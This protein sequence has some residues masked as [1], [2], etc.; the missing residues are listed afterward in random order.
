MCLTAACSEQLDAHLRT[1]NENPAHR[2]RAASS[3]SI[4]GGAPPPCGS[5]PEPCFHASPPLR[6]RAASGSAPEPLNFSSSCGSERASAVESALEPSSSAASSC[7]HGGGRA[8]RASHD[9]RAVTR[10]P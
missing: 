2:A 1:F 10:E 9:A 6:P 8:L 5:P 3:G 4:G 7:S